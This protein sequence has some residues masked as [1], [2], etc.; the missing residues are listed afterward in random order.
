[1]RFTILSASLLLLFA[2]ASCGSR[3]ASAVSDVLTTEMY[4][5]E[6]AGGF[7]ILGDS[8]HESVIIESVNPWQGADS[9]V[10]RL[11]IE[12][13]GEK[14][15][16]DFDGQVISGNAR[17]IVTMS[18]TQI[19][20]LDAIGATS[21]VYGVSGIDYIYNP[22]IQSRRDSRADVGFEGAVD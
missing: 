2:M 4:T 7:R 11:F 14:A 20:M 1:M 10:R 12:R 6:Y 5:P 3:N 22:G 13:G 9:T 15:P 17:R 16:A 21:R 19:A 8:A 18:S